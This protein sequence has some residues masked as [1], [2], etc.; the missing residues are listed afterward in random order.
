MVLYGLLVFIGKSQG[1]AASAA[2]FPVI[3]VAVCWGWKAG[4][5]AGLCAFPVNMLV[6][7]AI[8]YDWRPGMLSPI[9]LMG[10]TLFI[11]Q[12]L[13]IGFLR[14]LYLQ[15]QDA[16][17]RLQEE[18]RERMTALHQ[19]SITKEYLEDVITNSLDAIVIADAD[20]RITRVNRAL[21]ELTGRTMGELIGQTT[22]SLSAI[23]QGTYQS[24]DRETVVIDADFLEV[25]RAARER[26]QSEGSIRNWESYLVGK[27]RVLVP[28]EANIIVLTD[29]A[30]RRTGMVGILRDI[31]HRRRTEG[32]LKRH[33]DHLNDLVQEKTA[34]LSVVNEKLA[35]SNQRLLERELLLNEAQFIARIGNW[36]WNFET[37]ENRW[38]DQFFRILGY[39]PGE[40]APSLDLFIGHILHDDLDMVLESHRMFD[41]DNPYLGARVS[42]HDEKRRGAPCGVACLVRQARGR[43]CHAHLRDHAGHLCAQDRG[44]GFETAGNRSAGRTGHRTCR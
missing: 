43:Q 22:D 39:E 7:I 31:T 11:I 4:L 9:G 20:G 44:R 40:V 10:H 30:G 3:T 19:L 35:E 32:E 12:G 16:E 34:E 33:R 24:F 23:E 29:S 42:H 5:A 14:D 2:L 37:G 18:A 21:L 36:E 26:L 1:H 6:L 13:L 25:S 28:V 27:S 17:K 8:G 15:R 38:S 41:F